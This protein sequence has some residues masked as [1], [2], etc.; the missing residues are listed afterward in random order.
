MTWFADAFSGRVIGRVR[1]TTAGVGVNRPASRRAWR[2]PA[3]ETQCRKSPRKSTLPR[4]FQSERPY[5][6]PRPSESRRLKFPY[7]PSAGI[8]P[9]RRVFSDRSCF[10]RKQTKNRNQPPA[11]PESATEIDG[12]VC[13]HRQFA[14]TE[15][16]QG[17][18]NAWIKDGM[19]KH[20][21][22]VIFQKKG[23]CLFKDI[24]WCLLPQ[25]PPH[26][27]DDALSHIGRDHLRQQRL[28]PKL[29]TRRIDALH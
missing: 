10:H 20:V 16:P 27:H 29:P 7:P 11:P 9:P 12:L 28:H 15:L 13:Q 25:C 21:L 5:Q 23:H 2:G 6:N 17:F 26:Q 24:S 19:I 8:H 1:L 22:S 14:C 3:C 18:S 4:F